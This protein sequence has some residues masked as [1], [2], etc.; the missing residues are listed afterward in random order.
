[1]NVKQKATSALSTAHTS[2]E[3]PVYCD[4]QLQCSTNTARPAAVL[5]STAVVIDT[6][7][8][9]HRQHQQQIG[10]RGFVI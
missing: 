10:T 4:G 3:R 5:S 7:P 9:L 8:N 2:H 1:M 6:A